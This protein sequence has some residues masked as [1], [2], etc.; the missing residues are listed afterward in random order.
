MNGRSRYYDRFKHILFEINKVSNEKEFGSYLS[1]SLQCI[2]NCLP[3]DIIL[4]KIR[5]KCIWSIINNEI[6]YNTTPPPVLP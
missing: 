5:L 2:T 1:D 3:L 6:L 4:E